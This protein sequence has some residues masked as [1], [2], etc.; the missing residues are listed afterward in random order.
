VYS[1]GPAEQA[2][3]S[4]DTSGSRTQLA[5]ATRAAATVR[6]NSSNGGYDPTDIYNSNAYDYAALNNLKHCCNPNHVPNSSPPQGSVAI[7]TIGQQAV[8]DITGFHTEY[9]Y[10]ADLFNEVFI[11]GTPPPGDGEGTL[12][13]EWV[14]ATANSFGCQCDTAHVWLYDGAN[15]NASTFSDIYNHMLNDNV[16]RVMSVSWGCAEIF[17]STAAMMDSQHAIFNAMLGQGWTLVGISHDKGAFADCAH[18]SV[19]YPGSDPDVVSSGGT[20]LNIS[21]NG[22]FASQTAWQ[23]NSFGCANNGGGSGGGCSA[24]FTAAPYQ[25]AANTGCG[26]MRAVPDIALNA[27]WLNT[28]QNIFVNGAKQVNGGTSIVAPMVAG[29]FA[30]EDSYML[31]MGQGPLGNGGASLYG[32]HNG[33]APHNPYYDITSGCNGSSL[34]AGFCAKAGYDLVTGLGSANMLQLAWGINWREIPDEGRP[35]VTFSGPA[36]NVW[37]NGVTPDVSWTVADTNAG[38]VQSGLAGFSESIDSS[39]PDPTAHATPGSGDPFYSGPQFPGLTHLDVDW[40]FLTQGC[41]SVHVMAWDNTGLSSQDQAYGPVCFDNA[42]PKITQGPSAFLIPTSTIHSDGVPVDVVWNATDNASGVAS[43]SVQRKVDNGPF[44]TV[45]LDSDTDTSVGQVLAP[46]HTYQY[47]VSATD[48]AGNTSAPTTAKAFKVNL[49]QENQGVVYSAGWAR[50]ALKGASGGSVDFTTAKAKTAKF[51]FTG[52]QVGWVTTAATNHG[53]ATVSV[54]GKAPVKIDTSVLAAIVPNAA[55]ESI[56]AT[57]EFTRSFARGKHT[58]T[59]TNLATAKRPRIDLD[60][61]VFLS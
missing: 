35:T 13:A 33:G 28:P 11:D 44:T 58:I 24:H 49:V 21:A 45:L 27:D 54:D 50:Q 38:P 36:T 42:P 5:A 41:H 25:I 16:A 40:A 14:T 20:R 34:G 37:F 23:P 29:F 9:P 18:L 6:P 39:V 12:D 17:C 7:A 8:S 46:G 32:I 19:S 57:I 56:P 3:P 31:A 60:A 51:T 22:S 26:N 1:P 15:T 43:Y 53:A 47:R 55:V 48:A 10:L 30:Q 59:I 2:G 52:S 61:F 4:A